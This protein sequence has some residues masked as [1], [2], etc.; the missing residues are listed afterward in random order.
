MIEDVLIKMG[1]FI[2]LVDFVVL[3]LKRV[4]DAKSYIPVILGRPFLATFNAF[5]N[6]WNGMM[7]LSFGNMTLDFN[8]F[9]L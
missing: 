5:I 3:D 8:I 7:K 2:F 1:K 9:N 4:P 6:C